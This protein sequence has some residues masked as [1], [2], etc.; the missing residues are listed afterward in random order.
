VGKRRYLK[1]RLDNLGRRALCASS[2]QQALTRRAPERG[3]FNR[4]KT[5]IAF[6]FALTAALAHCATAQAERPVLNVYYVQSPRATSLAHVSDTNK[7]IK[8]VMKQDFKRKIK[9]RVRGIAETKSFVYNSSLNEFW[10]Y[11]NHYKVRLTTGRKKWALVLTPPQLDAS[12][13]MWFIG[14]GHTQCWKKNN[15]L[16]MG[17]ASLALSNDKGQSRYLQ[18]ILGTLHELGHT[19]SLNHSTDTGSIMHSGVLYYALN[20]LGFSE[21]EK[22]K[23]K[24]CLR[25]K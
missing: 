6:I 20:G 4:M 25:V 16:T 13:K 1:Y 2:E 9:I 8:A 7:L 12:G 15:G 14:R 10:H 22:F 21:S 5:Q 19:L 24:H 18:T 11:A 23:A 3:L 17:M